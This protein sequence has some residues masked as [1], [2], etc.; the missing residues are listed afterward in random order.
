MRRM[1][2]MMMVIRRRMMNEAPAFE[3]IPKGLCSSSKEL[4][5]YCSVRQY[6]NNEAI[7]VKYWQHFS[8]F[9]GPKWLAPYKLT[10]LG[11]DL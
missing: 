9:E 8:G 6:L 10:G 3:N 7:I 1:R 2:R 4:R 5:M 11:S